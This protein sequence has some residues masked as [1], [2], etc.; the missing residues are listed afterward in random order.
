M[1]SPTAYVVAEQ[2]A[3]R[4]AAAVAYRA[5][6]EAAP[7]PA[8]PSERLVLRR[9]GSFDDAV[10]ARLAQLD[11]APRPVGAVLVAE[12][13][14]EIVAALPFDGGRAIADPFRPTAELVDLLRTR[15]RVLA[16]A[17]PKTRRFP[18]LRP[19]LRPRIAA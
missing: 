14:G 7:L 3:D 8:A 15:V 16:D 9:S 12:L 19:N 18:R 11:S 6:H 10:L 17:A 5:A 1:L 4:Q 2:L 13:D